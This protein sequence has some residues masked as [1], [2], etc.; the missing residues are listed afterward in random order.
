MHVSPPLDNKNNKYRM[1]INS[2]Q[3]FVQGREER[4]QTHMCKT[5]SDGDTLVS[6]SR[7]K[8]S[9]RVDVETSYSVWSSHVQLSV[10]ELTE[11]MS[12]TLPSADIHRMRR[13]HEP[14]QG[15][16]GALGFPEGDFQREVTPSCFFMCSYTT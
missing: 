11:I 2:L 7:Q 15:P 5:L 3:P 1:E 4:E 14:P 6:S 16:P 8:G 10:R 9:K 12:S 13:L